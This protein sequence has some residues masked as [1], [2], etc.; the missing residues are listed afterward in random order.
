MMFVVIVYSV[1]TLS[2]LGVKFV[3]IKGGGSS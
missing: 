1:P 2:L 3:S